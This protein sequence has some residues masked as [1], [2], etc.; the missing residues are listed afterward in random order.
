MPSDPHTPTCER[1]QGPGLLHLLPTHRHAAGRTGLVRRD[2]QKVNNVR[3]A[4][5][6]EEREAVLHH[7]TGVGEAAVVQALH[8]R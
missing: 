2:R 6:A 1:R 4:G 7:V 3:D 8:N 5:A